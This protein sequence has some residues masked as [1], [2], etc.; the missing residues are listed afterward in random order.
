VCTKWEKKTAREENNQEGPSGGGTLKESSGH[1][2][3]IGELLREEAIIHGAGGKH[4]GGLTCTPTDTGW[5][6]E[7]FMGESKNQWGGGRR[8][9][10]RTNSERCDFLPERCNLFWGLNDKVWE[11]GMLAGPG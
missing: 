1:R 6:V 11:A 9:L 5:G 2:D 8:E 4:V 7:D 3:W 10:H